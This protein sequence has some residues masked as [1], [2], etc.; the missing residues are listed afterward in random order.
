[1]LQDRGLLIVAA[2]LAVLIL[3]GLLDSTRRDN[4]RVRER[5]SPML[6]VRAVCRDRT[7]RGAVG[8]L[9]PLLQK[10]P[11]L[12][13]K[14]YATADAGITGVLELPLP[15]P[16]PPGFEAELLVAADGCLTSREVVRAETPARTLELTA[17]TAEVPPLDLADPPLSPT[18]PPAAAEDHVKKLRAMGTGMST[19]FEL[20]DGVPP[21]CVQ[22]HQAAGEEHL[23]GHGRPPSEALQRLSQNATECARCHAPV[24]AALASDLRAVVP[25]RAA[26]SCSSCHRF[27][28]MKD[29]TQGNGLGLGGVFSAT[30]DR[31]F[32]AR[33]TR[34]DTSSPVM[35]V[36]HAPDMKGSAL[37]VACH[38][39][40]SSVD[41]RL[42][43]LDPTGMEHLAW[44]QSA[45]GNASTQCQSCHFAKT[46]DPFLVDG[47]ARWMWGVQR[48]AA[49]RVAH[50]RARQDLAVRL[51]A[52]WED[53][54]TLVVEAQNVG[55]SHGLP[56]AAPL[57]AWELSVV[58]TE[59]PLS[60]ERLPEGA[61]GVVL[62]RSFTDAN[63][64]VC[65]FPWEAV[66]VAG[67]SRLLPGQMVRWTWRFERRHSVRVVLTEKARCS[68]R[69][70]LEALSTEVV[71]LSELT[72]QP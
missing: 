4:E 61:P 54:G 71:V 6:E 3:L 50:G 14:V 60:G 24:A 29:A 34:P 35:A 66:A 23:R 16:T 44:Q 49:P 43:V 18:F 20:F 72:V 9:R 57:R 47:Y 38:S 5:V 2:G 67:D 40:T 42:L 51:A 27:K 30:S 52:H 11:Q 28:P 22:C 15:W 68:E 58:T 10:A 56:G 12:V 19:G 17:T 21:T 8:T 48:D 55:A 1:M 64:N 39:Q 63:K 25:A 33:G 7:A 36:E 13:G 53:A 70:R 46:E 32:F 65:A 37:C 26:F 45:P 62:A 41:G 69:A 31:R 59:K